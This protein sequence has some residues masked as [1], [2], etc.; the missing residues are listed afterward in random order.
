[1]I[2]VS[3]LVSSGSPNKFLK[4]LFFQLGILSTSMSTISINHEEVRN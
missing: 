4:E 1:M 3:M 2:N